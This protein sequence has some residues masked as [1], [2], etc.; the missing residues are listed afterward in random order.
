MVFALVAS[1]A[2]AHD[3]PNERVDRSIQVVLRP[4]RLE[5]AYEV[6]LAELTLLQD[7]RRLVGPVSAAD[8]RGLF[9][10]YG[11]ETSPL[12]ARGLLLSIDGREV[13]LGPGPFDLAIEEHP[14]F[15]FHFRADLPPSGRLRLRDGNYVDSE[16]TSRL[17]I[18]GLGVSIAGDSLPP[19][20]ESIP[21]RPVWQLTDAEERRTKEVTVSFSTAGPP[22]PGRAG[23]VSPLSGDNMESQTGG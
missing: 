11:R 23:G 19:D 3:I 16:G 12:T 18:R 10:R 20:V 13:S 6:S 21:I 7:L 15:T 5:V 1:A 22:P 8:P 17:A 14:R 4:G 9:E 2:T